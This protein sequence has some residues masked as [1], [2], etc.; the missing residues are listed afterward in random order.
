[1]ALLSV[2]I[3][4]FDEDSLNEE[5]SLGLSVDSLKSFSF[6]GGGTRR[7][8]ISFSVMFLLGLRLSAD[9]FFSG[10]TMSDRESICYSSACPLMSLS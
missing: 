6:F 3:R 10:S 4:L 2:V 5:F 1:M 9:S 8:N 7:F